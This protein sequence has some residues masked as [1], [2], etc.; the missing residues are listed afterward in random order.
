MTMAREAMG[1]DWTTRAELVEAIPPAFSEHL[2][3]QTL[4]VLK[5]GNDQAQR[6]ALGEDSNC[7]PKL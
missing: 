4:R 1:I 7:K 3:R 5:A 2:A 6:L